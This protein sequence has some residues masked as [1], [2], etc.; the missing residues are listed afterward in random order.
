M[1]YSKAPPMG[2]LNLGVIVLNRQNLKG[3]FCLL[4]AVVMVAACVNTV[5][6]GEWSGSGKRCTQS[7]VLMRCASLNFY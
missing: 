2:C 6:V 4:R 3:L 7:V 1:D 5:M